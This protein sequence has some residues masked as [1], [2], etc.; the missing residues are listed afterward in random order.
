MI[1]KCG[2][3]GYFRGDS[4]HCGETGT[5]MLDDEQTERLG[6]F[7]SGA[8]RHFPDDLGL[9]MNQHGWVDAEVLCD[10]MKTRY[11]W[12]SKDKLF[13]II[14]SDEKGRYEIQGR[15][16]RARYG[17]SVLVD[18]DY[19]KNEHHLLYY[20]ASRE[21][22]DILLEKGIRP[23]KQRYVHLSTTIE[24]AMEVAKIHTD[25]PVLIVINASE[26]QNDGVTILNATEN[27]VLADEIP[28][29]YLNL[30]ESQT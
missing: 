7:I 11:K 6:R 9:A 16:I 19:P 28:P 24:K 23:I 13:S 21:E 25:D 2:T 14:E 30:T 17:H 1:K 18:L 10:A 29:Q 27:I 26:A 4:C 20:G 3:H 22:V 15:K 12:A 5:L 8:L